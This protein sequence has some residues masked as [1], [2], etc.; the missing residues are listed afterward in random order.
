MAK[1]MIRKNST[2]KSAKKKI[3]ARKKQTAAPFGNEG[4]SAPCICEKKRKFWYCMKIKPNG[5]KVQCLGPYESKTA[6][7][8]EAFLCEG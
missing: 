2:I 8:A 4:I 3:P 6:C 7:E 1:K 5:S